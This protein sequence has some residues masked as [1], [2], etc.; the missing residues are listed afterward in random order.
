MNRVFVCDDEPKFVK[1]LSDALLADGYAV[2]GFTSG[3]ELIKALTLA[4]PSEALIITDLRMDGLDGMGVL[5]K[6]K[7]L[8][9]QLEVLLMTAYADAKTAVDAMKLGA[10]DYLIKPFKLDELQLIVGRIFDKIALLAENVH[11][12]RELKQVRRTDLIG[13]SRAMNDVRQLIERV[14]PT[15]H[16][17]LIQGE[18]GTGKELVARSIHDMSRRVNKPFIA[19]NVGALPEP[20]LESELFG[21]KKG[22]FT[23]AASNKVGLMEQANRGTLFLDEVGEMPMSLQVKLLRALQER[24]IQPLGAAKQVPIDIRIVAATNRNVAREVE[25]GAFRA[26][27]YYRLNVFPIDVPPLRTRKDDLADLVSYFLSQ[28]RANKIAISEPAFAVLMAHDWPG[29]IR[30]LENQIQRA[31]LLCDGCTIEP[32]HLNLVGPRRG[33]SARYPDHG[34]ALPPDGVALDDLEKNLIL[35][36]LDAAQHNKSAAA[37]LLGIS[38]RRLYSKMKSHGIATGDE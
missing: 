20:L 25:H 38:R 31:V 15:D 14:A 33:S 11:L 17:V 37:N 13:R 19:V 1:L 26:D 21:Y 34:F 32:K 7:Q 2:D 8:N 24:E 22:A 9:P 3:S 18:S 23:G 28:Q 12:K 36:A 35:Q 5:R 4:D 30:E 16:T 27:L 10:Y 6:A 29:N